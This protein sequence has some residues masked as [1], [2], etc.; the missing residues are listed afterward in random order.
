[1]ES[2]PSQNSPKTPLA[3]SGTG[4]ATRISP[5]LPRD[6]VCLIIEFCDDFNHGREA[7]L[8]AL[9]RLGKAYT[10]TA[11]RTLYRKIQ[12]VP[13]AFSFTGSNR[14]NWRLWEALE[15]SEAFQQS[16]EHAHLDV[17]KAIPRARKS[18][19]GGPPWTHEQ[20][21]FRKLPNV[22]TVSFSGSS[23]ETWSNTFWKVVKWLPATV[24]LLDLR[25]TRVLETLR[26]LDTLNSLDNFH[27]AQHHI[28]I[29]EG[30]R[31]RLDKI[32]V[33][34]GRKPSD[35]AFPHLNFVVE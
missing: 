22:K 3:T 7:T 4:N 16:V 34:E 33:A 25:R 30:L 14:S 9:C 13:G 26:A 15:R 11:Q 1:M 23:E 5:R 12:F 24:R 27:G 29:T 6:L 32:C 17:A 20:E 8:A 35:Q 28:L 18:E 31:M 2:A 10:S 19:P 21:L